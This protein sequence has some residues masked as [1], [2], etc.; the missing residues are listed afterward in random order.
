[1]R[2]ENGQFYNTHHDRGS[3]GDNDLSGGR[4]LTFFLYC[5]EVEEGGENKFSKL[6]IKSKFFSFF[7]F[8]DSLSE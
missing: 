4:I 1:M 2:Y 7:H 8:L 5:S 3:S 6:K